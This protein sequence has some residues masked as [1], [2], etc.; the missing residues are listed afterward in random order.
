M[1]SFLIHFTERVGGEE[2]RRNE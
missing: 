2:R 1:F